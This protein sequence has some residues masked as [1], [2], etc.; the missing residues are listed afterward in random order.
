M[1]DDL[2]RL[3]QTVS[4]VLLALI[5]LQ[6]PL[7]SAV[8]YAT[9]NDWLLLGLASLALA[10]V[11][12]LA[13]WQAPRSPSVRLMIAVALIASLSLVVAAAAGSKWQIDL[14]MCYFAE[15]AILTAYC[16]RDVV[17]A[18]AA[19]TA[20]H[21][22][23]LNFLLPALVFPDGAQLGRVLLHAGVLCAETVVLVWLTQ[24]IATL[25]AS[26]AANLA[27]AEREFE[28]ARAA[29][30]DAGQQRGLSEAVR[31]N[32]EAALAVAAEAQCAVVA[33]L[34]AGL[35]CLAEGDL[36]FRLSDPFAAEYE[37]LRGNFN[38]AAEH[39]EALIRGI[40]GN[41]GTIQA[42][43]DE[44]RTASDDLSR[45]TESQ[46]ASLEQ[47]AAALDEI[48]ATVRRAAESS[49]QV[50]AVVSRTKQG[51]EQSG[52]VVRQAV[53]AMGAIEQSS[54]KIG[55]I[56]GVIDEIAFQTNLLALNAGVE[57]ARAGDAGRGFAV[58]AS[59][60][61][62]LAQRSAQA[63]K[64]IKALVSNSAQQV[65]IGVNLVGEAGQALDRIVSEVAEV[66]QAVSD[67]ATS[68]QE[69]AAGLAEVNTAINQMDQVTQQN[70]AMV[71]QSTAA[72]HSLAQEAFELM[73]LT[74]RFR[75]SAAPGSLG[76]RAGVQPLRHPAKPA[77]LPAQATALGPAAPAGSAPQHQ[78]TLVLA[79]AEA[80]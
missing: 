34:A 28:A 9:G 49:K 77:R 75:I 78:P 12:T 35:A 64:E 24:R 52:Q 59:E 8:A 63:A 73:Q 6:V 76:V 51:A 14:H 39:I 38:S 11:A 25:F 42:G 10:A 29:E 27:A 7:A 72:S 15:L 36:V 66:T 45:R 2:D 20:L 65:G 62:A 1:R 53:V 61:R 56:I 44:I 48:T 55:D 40:V 30:A 67:I 47:T 50:L 23:A 70:A 4:R 80:G 18:G 16:D 37:A 17:L 60:V 41:A 19:T 79:S 31:Q 57:A 69:Q 13:W 68:A 54:Q 43:T 58:V 32:A 46:A 71:E 33:A 21:H 26:T 3:R 5:W 74:S 22:L